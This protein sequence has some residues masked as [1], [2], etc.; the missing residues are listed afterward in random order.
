ML[1]RR[2]DLSGFFRI[3]FIYIIFVVFSSGLVFAQTVILNQEPDQVGCY[4]SDVIGFF[5]IGAA[6]NFNLSNPSAI[7]QIRIWGAYPLNNTPFSTDNFTVVFHY[8]AAGLPGAVISTKTNVQ[9]SRQVTG[10]IIDQGDG[11]FTEYVF[12]LTLAKPVILSPGTYWVMITNV[13]NSL[14]NDDFY[15]ES[16]TVDPSYGISGHA[17]FQFINPW[18]NQLGDLAIEITAEPA[19]VGIP[20][21]TELGMIFMSLILAGSAFWAI[22]RRAS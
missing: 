6:D 18:I 16:G 8:D 14:S 3:L 20:S 13:D 9:S 7:T 4:A 5:L 1:K 11:N 15:W 2:K 10:K 17:N 12:I 21:M 22:R 19:Y